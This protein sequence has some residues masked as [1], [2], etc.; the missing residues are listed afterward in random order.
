[1]TEPRDV[2]LTLAGI[3]GLT[4]LESARALVLAG[5]RQSEAQPL[6]RRLVAGDAEP[7]LLER[8]VL[9]MYAYAYQL[10]R[11]EDPGATWDQAQTWRVTV[12][13]ETRDETADAEAEA[14]VDAAIVTGLPPDVAGELTLAQLEEYRSVHDE[15]AREL[16]RRRGRRAG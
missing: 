5:V 15:Q 16:R 1:V 7:E 12:D 6:L 11:R 14:S 13:V 2:V 9:L 3:R 4:V 10:E 8:A